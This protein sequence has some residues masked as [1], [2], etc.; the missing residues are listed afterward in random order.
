LASILGEERSNK[1]ARMTA[2]DRE[3]IERQFSR[4]QSVAEDRARPRIADT[5]RY[6]QLSGEATPVCPAAKEPLQEDFINLSTP[7]LAHAGV[8]TTQTIAAGGKQHQGVWTTSISL[9]G[10]TDTV[11]ND[12]Y[13]AYL[14]TDVDGHPTYWNKA[15]S[16]FL[17]FNRHDST[18]AICPR[19]SGDGEDL[20][21]V[22]QGG[23]RRGVAFQR[24]GSE[25]QEWCQDNWLNVHVRLTPHNSSNRSAAPSKPPPPRIPVLPSPS[26]QQARHVPT[27]QVDTVVFNGFNTTELNTH[28][29]VDTSMHIGGRSTYWDRNRQYFMYYQAAQTRWAVSKHESADWISSGGRGDD[30]LAD[31]IRGGIRGVA[32]EERKG[33]AT[34]HEFWNGTW[35]NVVPSMQRLSTGNRTA[36]PPL[37]TGPAAPVP[38][39]LPMPLAPQH[40]MLPTGAPRATVLVP[41]F[42]PSSSS[43]S[44]GGPI[45]PSSSWPTS[46]SN[47]LLGAPLAR[48]PHQHAHRQATAVVGPQDHA[49]APSASTYVNQEAPPGTDPRNQEEEKTVPTE[50]AEAPDGGSLEGPKVQS[51]SS[52]S[53]SSDSE[54]PLDGLFES[55][56][57]VEEANEQEEGADESGGAS[58]STARAPQAPVPSASPRSPSSVPVGAQDKAK[59]DVEAAELEELVEQKRQRKQHKKEKKL[60]WKK[61]KE[62][63]L[64][65][66]IRKKVEKE[67]SKKG[68]RGKKAVKDDSADSADAEPP[69]P[70]KRGLGERKAP[71]EPPSTRARKGEKE[72][73]RE[74]PKKSRGMGAKGTAG[75]ESTAEASG[76]LAAAPFHKASSTKRPTWSL[77]VSSAWP[78]AALAMKPQPGDV[79]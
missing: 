25:W 55:A 22:V 54:D 5:A 60:A 62:A 69:A 79:Q 39:P 37:I 10:L 61:K 35:V 59:T 1:L 4:R 41:S 11:L 63:Q 73:G 77:A 23:H 32:C 24:Q 50:V 44:S 15:R 21:E 45:F 38:T 14:G 49:I 75:Q 70:A 51:S 18:W 46:S 27:G 64:E 3:R 47:G 34:W 67:K 12:T 29:F 43:S 78:R 57:A 30:P 13:S 26:A 74:M 20:L 40:S 17:F 71:A 19:V 31:A 48:A 58:G 76:A 7:E 42:A 33:G 72:A 66:K 36:L 56:P 9:Q 52:S 68:K 28:F 65:A 16:H 2:F 6:G 53:S 8:V